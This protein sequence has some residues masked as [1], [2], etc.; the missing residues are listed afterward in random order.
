MP[1][2]AFRSFGTNSRVSW[3]WSMPEG[4][5]SALAAQSRIRR[6]EEESRPH[7][8]QTVGLFLFL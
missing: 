7:R 1:A 8:V 4:R 3:S 6:I 2:R 5:Q